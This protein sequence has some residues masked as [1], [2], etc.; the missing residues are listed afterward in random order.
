MTPDFP[1]S[2]QHHAPDSLAIDIRA[3]HECILFYITL[4]YKDAPFQEHILHK[5][6]KQWHTQTP[7]YLLA[8]IQASH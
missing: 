1:A 5:L 2:S 8:V 4:H 7:C 6:I 3:L